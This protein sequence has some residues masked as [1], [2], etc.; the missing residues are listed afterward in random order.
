MKLKKTLSLLLVLVLATSMLCGCQIETV[1]DVL[2]EMLPT[3]ETIST[4]N[5]I[6]NNTE[7][8]LLASE[9]DGE[10]FAVINN[11]IPFFSEEDKKSTVAFETY[12]E[13]DSLGRCGVAYANICKELMPT[14]KRE[15][16]SSVTPSGWK[17]KKYDFVDGGW[18]YNRAHI[19]GFQ[20][21]GEQANELNLI[22]GTRYFNVDG[23]LTFEN[24]VAD[25][26]K[27]D[28][29]HVL[30]RV[31]PVYEGNN[32]VAEG[33]IMEGW[34]VEDSGE[35]ICFN[36]FCYNVQPGVEIDYKTGDN[37]LKEENKESNGVTEN[38][39]IYILNI[40]SKKFHKENCNSV[41]S[42]SEKN[43][44]VQKDNRENLLKQGYKPC[45]SC[46]P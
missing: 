15:S 43:K 27:E 41:S 14:E 35:S 24:M 45:G 12:S 38:N 16:L 36:V 29:G 13:L 39:I 30:Y 40:N 31:T 33:V 3:Q 17:N 6:S 23:M 8:K 46:K 22:T 28:G 4:S 26:V 18:V 32:L 42:I 7:T 44:R 19:I 20:L 25:Y 37:W 1:N 5:E 10:P 9:Y 21:A 34:S 2:D 11:N